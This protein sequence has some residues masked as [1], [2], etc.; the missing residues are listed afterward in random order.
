VTPRSL[1][2]R[3]TALAVTATLGWSLWATCVEAGGTSA[4]QMACCVAGHHECSHDGHAADCCK[5]T[6]ELRQQFT[7]IAKVTAPQPEQAAAEALP[8]LITAAH[9]AWHHRLSTDAS[10]PGTKR[11]TYL[12]LST[13]RL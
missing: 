3:F 9:L 12:L 7:T 10:P 13:L 5:T 11:P 8:V 1:S 6:P 4:A 2:V